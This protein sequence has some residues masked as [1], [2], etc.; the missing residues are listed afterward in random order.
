M[1]KNLEIFNKLLFIDCPWHDKNLS[2]SKFQQQLHKLPK[3]S[4]ENQP[5][6]ELKFLKPLSERRKYYSAIIKNEA[7][8][9]KF[10]LN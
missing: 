6:L 8:S 10:R 7:I 2:E 3:L 4:V 5:L 9:C 1:S